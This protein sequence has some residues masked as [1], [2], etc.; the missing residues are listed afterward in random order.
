MV[1][2]SRRVRQRGWWFGR[3]PLDSAGGVGGRLFAGPP[4]KESEHGEGEEG[5]GETKAQ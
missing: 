5:A 1:G 3:L 2:G 4:E